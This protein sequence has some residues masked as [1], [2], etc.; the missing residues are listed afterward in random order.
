M[1]ET[2]QHFIAGEFREGAGE[3]M[4]DLN[5]ATGVTVA[6]V[7]IGS[8]QEVDEAVAAARTALDAG[9]ERSSGAERRKSLM[10]GRSSR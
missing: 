3:T 4:P 5:P 9:W 1:T 6:D 10:R 2:I 7:P 8:Q